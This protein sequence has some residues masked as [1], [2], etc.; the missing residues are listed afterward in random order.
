MKGEER[1]PGTERAAGGL[2][3]GRTRVLPAPA[4]SRAPLPQPEGPSGGGSP[5]RELGEL[6]TPPPH[7]C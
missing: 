7:S 5:A 3:G 1:H 6:G 2:G 4:C